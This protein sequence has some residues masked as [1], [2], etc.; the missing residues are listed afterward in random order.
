MSGGEGPAALRAV[1]FAQELA[2]ATGV[3]V[4][5]VDERLS[6]VEASR[7]LRA[8][9]VDARRGKPKVDG[10]A[11]AILLQTWLDGRRGPGDPGD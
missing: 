3:E 10:V 11:A 6:T 2:D 1:R 8:S 4:E 5:L 7:Q 9:G